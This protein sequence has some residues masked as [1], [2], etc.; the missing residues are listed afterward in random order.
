MNNNTEEIDF[1]VKKKQPSNGQTEI[2]T[3]KKKDPKKIQKK[4]EKQRKRKQLV[5]RKKLKVQAKRKSKPRNTFHCG[6][7]KKI[8][9]NLKNI[10]RYGFW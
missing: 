9:R 7:L 10:F 3:K 5:K 2:N 4:E 6:K 8:T 1:P